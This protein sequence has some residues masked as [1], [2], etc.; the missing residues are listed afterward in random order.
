MS[1]ASMMLE[2][3]NIVKE[4]LE[5]NKFKKINP[6]HKE[7]LAGTFNKYVD[8]EYLEDGGYWFIMYEFDFANFE[9]YMGMEY[10][11]EHILYK[12]NLGCSI[13]VCYSYDS[14]RAGE[15][16]ELVEGK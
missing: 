14:E 11:R 10:E 8:F 7:I 3:L 13:L 2:E 1:R 4:V 12:I 5:D 9:Y 15:L 16:I 6:A